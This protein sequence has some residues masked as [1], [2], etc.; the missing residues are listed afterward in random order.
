MG[1]K[2]AEIYRP[3]PDATDLTT[4]IKGI[5][6]SGAHIVMQMLTGPAG[7]SFIKQW[8][9]LQ[10]PCALTGINVSAQSKAMWETTRGKTEYS[11]T[12]VLVPNAEITPKTIPFFNKFSEKYQEYPDRGGMSYDAVWIYK[13]AVEKAGILD[14]DTMVTALEKTD[15]TGVAYQIVF[16][17]TTAPFPHDVLSS[18]TKGYAM[19]PLVQW[20]KGEQVCVWPPDVKG[21]QKY[22]IPPW[23]MD[24][25]KK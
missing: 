12:G 25:Y 22:Q 7:V 17:D 4:E 6:D 15:F 18:Q 16:G 23:M 24:F 3:S 14:S 1:I 8:G 11:S 21:I 10:I 19:I 13:N 5:K 2:V 20:I 9:E